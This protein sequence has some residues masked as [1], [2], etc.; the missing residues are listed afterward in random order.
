MKQV[1][2]VAGTRSCLAKF[3]FSSF[4]STALELA[5]QLSARILLLTVGDSEGWEQGLETRSV[6]G[7]H[8]LFS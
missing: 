6:P 1:T 5:P 7:P 8:P 3:T 4:P 2:Q